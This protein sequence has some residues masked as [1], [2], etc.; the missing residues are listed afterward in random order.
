M[1]DGATYYVTVTDVLEVPM[2]VDCVAVGGPLSRASGVKDMLVIV[3]IVIV[4][5]DG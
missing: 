2:Q 4:Q 3:A 5:A 1:L